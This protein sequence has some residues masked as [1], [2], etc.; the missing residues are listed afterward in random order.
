[1]LTPS[2]QLIGPK[3]DIL[4]RSLSCFWIKKLAVFEESVNTL[5]SSVAAATIVYLSPSIL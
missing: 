1:M 4:N 2:N 3:S 5:K